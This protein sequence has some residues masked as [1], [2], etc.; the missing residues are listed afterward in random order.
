MLINISL[1]R[2]PF[3]GR[4]FLMIM[5]LLPLGLQQLDGQSI[6]NVVHHTPVDL[7]IAE[8]STDLTITFYRSGTFTESDSLN[9]MSVTFYR[10]GM[11]TGSPVE[12]DQ[13]FGEGNTVTVSVPADYIPSANYTF[14]ISTFNTNIASSAEGPITINGLRLVDVEDQM[15]ISLSATDTLCTGDALSVVFT[16]SGAP[17][18]DN[19]YVIEL[20]DSS[21]SFAEPTEIGRLSGQMTSGSVPAMI[22]ENIVPGRGYR[23]QLR[24]TNPDFVYCNTFDH[25]YTIIGLHLEEIVDQDGTALSRMQSFCPGDYLGVVFTN[26]GAPGEGNSYVVELSDSSGS[27]ATPTVIGSL[28]GQMTSGTVPAIIPK[29]LLS[30]SGYQVRIRSTNPDFVYCNTFDHDYTIEDSPEV[31]TQP[32]LF[33]D[34]CTDVT[35]ST[36]VEGATDFQWEKLCLDSFFITLL[37]TAALGANTVKA[38]AK[39]GDKLY[40]GTIAGLSYYD[41]SSWAVIN[42]G[43]SNNFINDIWV[44]P[45]YG[46]VY[47]STDGGFTI[48]NGSGV[49]QKVVKYPLI[50]SQIVNAIYSDSNHVFVATS[51]GLNYLNLANIL[52][53]LPT[54]S[55]STVL[56][57][58][59]V[60]SVAAYEV[61][62]TDRII[63][64]GTSSGLYIGAITGTSGSPTSFTGPVLIEATSYAPADYNFVNDV[65]VD[66]DNGTIY[67]ATRVG[68]AYST[69]GGNDWVRIVEG[70]E[71]TVVSSIFVENGLIFATT[72]QGL[73]VAAVGTEAFTLYTSQQ[74]IGYGELSSGNDVFVTS[75]TSDGTTTYSVNV[76]STGGLSQADLTLMDVSDAGSRI[77]GATTAELTINPIE[78]TD[79]LCRYRLRVS[80]GSSCDT[81]SRF[82]KIGDIPPTPIATQVFPSSNCLKGLG[83]VEISGLVPGVSYTLNYKGSDSGIPMNGED[84]MA[85]KLDNSG[86]IQLL[87]TG[88]VRISM[89]SMIA[90]GCTSDTLAVVIEGP[91]PPVF[92]DSIPGNPPA[93]PY[94]VNSCKGDQ[95]TIP[96]E[97]LPT[98]QKYRWFNHAAL[99]GSYT[100]TTGDYQPYPAPTVDTTYYAIVRDDNTSCI[101]EDTLQVDVDIQDRPALA[102]DS[103]ARPS[104]SDTN[105]GQILLGGLVDGEGYVITYT[106]P[107]GTVQTVTPNPVANA[108]GQILLTTLGGGAYTNIQATSLLTGCSSSLLTAV[109]L[110][111]GV[112]GPTD[113][114]RDGEAATVKE[115]SGGT[116][117]YFQTAN[118]DISCVTDVHVSAVAGQRGMVVGRVRNPRANIPADPTNPVEYPE[119]SEVSFNGYVIFDLYATLPAG[120]YIDKVEFAAKAGDTYS[121]S[122]CDEVPLESATGDIQFDITRMD[123]TL[124]YGPYLYGYNPIVNTDLENQKYA[125]FTVS[126]GKQGA[127]VDLGPQAVEDIQDRLARDGKFQVGL[128]LSG[129]DFDL[130]LHRFYGIVFEPGQSQQLRVTYHVRD[131]GDLS[132]LKYTVDLAGGVEGPWHRADSVDVDPDTAIV[133][134]QP[135]A[136]LGATPPDGE[137][138]AFKSDNATGDDVNRTSTNPAITDDEDLDA[139]IFVDENGNP[140]PLLAGEVVNVEIPARNNL[141]AN[142]YVYLFIDFNSDGD[143]ADEGEYH[144]VD[145]LSTTD[146]LLI[147]PA[148]GIDT[149]RYSFQAPDIASS[150]SIAV[151]VRI[152][153]STTLDAN[154]GAPNG[155]VED[156]LIGL[157]AKDFGDLQDKTAANGP[158]DFNTL[159]YGDGPRHGVPVI[160]MVYLGATVD[161]E[162]DGQP[163]DEADGD[164]APNDSL[165][166]D[167]DGVIFLTPFVPGKQATIRYFPNNSSDRPAMFYVFGDLNNDGILDSLAQAMIPANS[168]ALAQNLTFDVPEDATFDGGNA[169]FRFRITT[170]TSLINNPPTPYGPAD[171]GEV[172]DYSLPIFSIGNLV[173][174][175][176]NHNGFQDEEEISLG[177][178]SMRVVLRY[179][180]T[181]DDG[182]YDEVTQI[183]TRTNPTTLMNDGGADTV[184]DFVLDTL[185]A[186][187][188]TYRFIGLIE[189]NYQLIALD[190]FDLTPTRANWIDYVTEEDRDSDGIPLA[191][192]WA[193]DTNEVHQ[194]RT[195]VFLLHRDS[196]GTDEE[197]ILDQLNPAL[198]DPNQLT[199][200]PDNRFEQRIDFGYVAFDFGDLPTTYQTLEDSVGIGENVAG[201]FPNDSVKVGNP[202]E[203]PKHIVTPDIYLGECADAERLGQPDLDAGAEVWNGQGVVPAADGLG[204][205]PNDGGWNTADQN[206]TLA[207]VNDER[208]VTFLTPLVPGSE[209][210]ITVKFHASINLDGPDAYLQAYFDWNGD[211]DFY[212]NAADPAQ[213]LDPDEQ[214]LF[215]HLN[216]DT[217]LL[218]ANT[219]AVGLEMSDQ[220]ETGAIMLKF[221]VPEAALFQ[222]GN[223]LGRFRIGKVPGLGPTGILP[224]T[225]SFADGIVPLGE[226]EDYFL[227]LVRTSYGNIVWEDRDYDG[228][229]DWDEP[230]IPGVKVTIEYAGLDDV[231]GNDAF[232]QTYTTQTNADGAFLFAGLIGAETQTMTGAKYYR[233]IVEDPDNMTPTVNRD[234][235]DVFDV[236]NCVAYNS[237]GYDTNIDDRTTE[238]YFR[239]EGASAMCVGEANPVGGNDLGALSV[240]VG[241]TWPDNQIDETID[242]GFVAFDY[243]DLPDTS[244][245]GSQEYDYITSRDWLPGDPNYMGSRHAIQPRLY[246]G[247]GVDGELNGQPDLDAGSKAGGD[248]DFTGEDIAPFT[249]GSVTDGDDENGI[250][251]LTP[252]LPGEYAFIR[253]DYTSQDTVLGGGYADRQAFLNAFIDWNGDGDFYEGANF[254]AAEAITFEYESYTTLEDGEIAAIATP[255][256]NGALPGGENLY[257]IFG[258]RVPDTLTAQFYEGTAFM[259]FRLSWTGDLDPDNRRYHQA[260]GAQVVLDDEP[261]SGFLAMPPHTIADQVDALSWHWADT[262]QTYPQGEVED[263]AIPLAKVGNLSWYDHNV[264]GRQDG[265]L[266][267]LYNTYVD[268]YGVDTLHLV[269]IWGGVDH[270]TGDFDAVGYQDPDL[271]SA[272]DVFDLQY[273]LSIAPQALGMAPDGSYEPV[274][275]IKTNGQGLYSFRG[276]IPGNYYL[277]PLKYL[278]QDSAAFVNYWPKHRVLTVKQNVTVSDSLD[279]DAGPGLA[280]TIRD[281][282]PR[283]PEAGVDSLPL[284]EDGQLD[285]LDI[286]TMNTGWGITDYHPSFPDSLYDQTLDLG[287]VDEPNIETVLDLVGVDYPTTETGGN[288]N[289]IYHLYIKNPTE[290]P[291]DSIV[292]FLNIAGGYGDAF[293][294]GTAE[295]SIV[296]RAHLAKW[297][298]DRLGKNSNEEQ[299][300]ALEGSVADLTPYINPLYKGRDEGMA[301][302][303]MLLTGGDVSARFYLPGDSVICIRIEFEVNTDV[304]TREKANGV[305]CPWMLRSGSYARAVGFSYDATVTN[306]WLG[307]D[308]KVGLIDW[309]PRAGN[310]DANPRFGLPIEVSDISDEF[311]DLAFNDVDGK[312]PADSLQ[313]EGNVMDRGDVGEYTLFAT[314]SQTGRDKYEDEDD[315]LVQNDEGWDKAKRLSVQDNIIV[316]LDENC[317]A[318]LDARNFVNNYQKNL[319]FDVYPEGSYYR[320]IIKD[321]YTGEVL[322]AS[323]DRIPF[324]GSQYLDRKLIFEVRTVADLATVTWGRITI[325]DKLS[326]IVTCAENIDRDDTNNMLLN[327]MAPL[328]CTDIDSILNNPR[329]YLDSTYA[330]FTGI[331]T[332][333]DNCTEEVIF[334]GANDVLHVFADCDQSTA[335]G[336]AYAKITRTFL[337][338]DIFGNTASC[339]QEIYFYRPQIIL[340]DC[341]VTL[342]YYDVA[343]DRDLTPEDLVNTY[344]AYEAV[345][346]IINAAGDVVYLTDETICSFGISWENVSTFVSGE[347]TFKIEREWRV[348][349]WCY[350]DAANYPDY[351]DTLTNGSDCYTDASRE[352]NIYTFKQVLRVE[353]QIKPLVQIPDID[354]DGFEGSGYY[355]GPQA[356]PTVSTA[357]YDAEDVYVFSQ[358]TDCLA[359][360]RVT[361][362]MFRVQEDG[363]WC[364]D[365]EDIMVRQPVLDLDD[366][367]IPG[368]YEMVYD[369]QAQ[370]SGDCAGGYAVSAVRLRPDTSEHYLMRLRFFD[371]C[372]NDT[373]LYA[374]FEVLDAVKPV[375]LCKD[376]LRVTFDNVGTA[377]IHVED[378]DEG[379]YDNCGLLIWRKLRRPVLDCSTG[380]RSMPGYIDANNN[381]IIDE[382]DYIDENNNYRAEPLEYFQYN[383]EGVLMSPLLDQV[384][385]FCCD[386]DSVQV[387]LWASDQF[388]NRSNCWQNVYLE[389]KPLL[390]YALPGE[391]ELPANRVLHCEQEEDQL[392]WL[393]QSGVFAEGSLSYRAATALLGSDIVIDAPGGCLGF[394]KAIRLEPDFGACGFG[395]VAVSWIL[396]SGSEELTTPTRYIEVVAHHAY[397]IKFPQDAY[398]NCLSP[399]IDSVELGTAGCDLMAISQ[400]PDERFETPEDPTSCYKILRTWQVINWCEYDGISAPTIVSRDWDTQQ[401]TDC[402]TSAGAYNLNPIQPQ[403]DGTPGD[404]PIYVI[405]DI[406]NTATGT[407]T[408]YYDN[409]SYP[410]NTSTAGLSGDNANSTDEG[411]WWAV[412]RADSQQ[413]LEACSN[414]PDVWGAAGVEGAVNYGSRGFWQYTQHIIVQDEQDPDLTVLH[415]DTFYTDNAADCDAW[416]AISV[417]SLDGCDVLSRPVVPRVF[418]DGEEVSY[419]SST[420][421]YS[422]RYELGTHEL[423][424]TARD[425]CGNVAVH[426]GL[427]EVVDGQAPVPIIQE[428]VVVELSEKE[429]GGEAQLWVTDLIASDVYDCNGQQPEQTDEWGN[430]LV[431]QYSINRLGDTVDMEQSILLFDC[432]DAGQSVSIAVHAWDAVGNHAYAVTEVMVQD[433]Q[434]YCRPPAKDGRISGTIS[435]PTNG[436]LSAVE[437][438]LSGA[439]QRMEPTDIL[440]GYAMESLSE[441][442]DY[443]VTPVKDNFHGNGITTFDAILLQKHIQGSSSLERPYLPIAADVNRSGTITTLDLILLRKMI[444]GID[445]RFANN[446]SWRFV[447]AAYRFPAGSDPLTVPFPEARNVNNL[448]GDLEVNFVAIKTGDLN[449]SALVYTQPRSKDVLTIEA[450]GTGPW[451]L[452]DEEYRIDFK[453]E[454]LSKVQGYQFTLEL[455]T[456]LDLVDVIY[457]TQQAEHLGVF[458]DRG[459][460]TA[461]WNGLAASEALFSVV[462]RPREAVP[463]AEAIVLTS[464]YTTAEAYNE[465]DEIMELELSWRDVAGASARPVLYQ[466]EPNPYRAE[467]YISFHQVQRGSA[468]LQVRDVHGRLLLSRVGNYAAGLHTVRIKQEELPG[469][470]VY[471]YTL[472]TGNFVATRKMILL[473]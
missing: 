293:V 432:A 144:I 96:M 40:V 71:E 148:M 94:T 84:F 163:S 271:A 86:M 282:N 387:E 435:T 171:D 261:A 406:D 35:F 100:A 400:L 239:I 459:V 267:A 340:P 287:W 270:A 284:A 361:K 32:E 295:V 329:S 265:A 324:D 60:S 183:A 458:K 335:N 75:S 70:L 18:A 300:I 380:F 129:T 339:E 120:I 52:S 457:E 444:L 320:V 327:A 471:Y 420:G 194:A 131:Y 68:I 125:D 305:D 439:E 234:T 104:D 14:S 1:I 217:L 461:S 318:W 391:Y 180:G 390:E 28:P 450:S 403:G 8:G 288:F 348:L 466:N 248:D 296:E 302:D 24:S 441:G 78:Y 182:A 292:P 206:D 162:L 258:F 415:Q 250:R 274:G 226:V 139:N 15:G 220:Q 433:N 385:F 67:V 41:G 285:A 29:G 224:G 198:Q 276:L 43:L 297:V 207:C 119:P 135:T 230:V 325:E 114:F 353:D 301:T 247:D 186:H 79:A 308:T 118:P 50:S 95:I 152:S 275:I 438:H 470:G 56:V 23:I 430:A 322:W 216:G 252:L 236:S 109:L 111:Y 45:I 169:F 255:G 59:V 2:N 16:N 317:E 225:A 178:D 85:T 447:D 39:N 219:H 238:H 223:F 455:A 46:L 377:N 27:F 241:N 80:N 185:T 254:D 64:A 473:E 414:L 159:Q 465:E 38:V 424:V 423:L 21:G 350:S 122:L 366:R 345:P 440:G 192:P 240:A 436:R 417:S 63:Y 370:I 175:D 405:V 10:D 121:N 397:W 242:F 73:A 306:Q 214:I 249:Q 30:G 137:F 351:L 82:S 273:N 51:G 218:E 349:D 398:A 74:G 449:G 341:E 386:A 426:S 257:K 367:P 69:N 445:D 190:S 49:V 298:A 454:D 167:E 204:D 83:A 179:G 26:S 222:N 330:Y 53:P 13:T 333:V 62:A 17:S 203:G 158:N 262:L 172:E 142:V 373:L 294:P 117:G 468:S 211:G 243:G 113:N 448:E 5:L 165:S 55:F 3:E 147:V 337:F 164:D 212:L 268:E 359:S 362:D 145:T 177:I 89:T 123:D 4:S 7:C 443:T 191:A 464:S 260:T 210:I 146:S 401:G 20:S 244:S 437:V 402:G 101:S 136:F 232:E 138:V 97:D 44:D 156:F 399:M 376:A 369:D 37:D 469:A 154:G 58:N 195:E 237:D 315:Y 259:R 77:M 124:N 115:I 134:L 290:T 381:S 425:A 235:F 460:I 157:S 229:Q 354:E 251:L 316:G 197:G 352:G 103:T 200:F 110:P 132:E 378:V 408:V 90:P 279:S 231:F 189:G 407:A 106:D 396:S 65:F 326:P 176:R 463:R 161:T 140:T 368:A 334:D 451:L 338:R 388:G 81:Y 462:V 205:N 151:R 304:Y 34:T 413:D 93:D 9:K 22:P 126:S 421:Q 331:A 342:Y 133:N 416:V 472:E 389:N 283:N 76:A 215:T 92:G 127:W 419:S 309:M 33:Y 57:P 99:T 314:F 392:V 128:T 66:P 467:T 36:T 429:S 412:R 246:L 87:D 174:E 310:G 277:V 346:Y 364:F 434:G 344:G 281:E 328:V 456:A 336:Y 221:Q 166:D 312:M 360:F 266:E 253:V 141:I 256:V 393:Q 431:T 91:P 149:A 395:R 427:F 188:G 410:F 184:V 307:G 155:E 98:G 88:L 289:V 263:Y 375:L 196:L 303:T 202:L 209:A 379:S 227:N 153:S 193:Y 54:P 11:A 357:T 42:T 382:G 422:G 208:G 332:A 319:G 383:E 321:E 108:G 245:A 299:Q 25:D 187:N 418:I 47:L 12:T 453:C 168:G 291:L 31:T 264:N 150:D 286:A 61:N 311:D 374:P 442:S 384:P 446:T 112:D 116:S 102:I 323:V 355:N 201:I 160:P 173:W 404:E 452:A 280:F 347:C 181:R 394:E 143:F 107:M 105:D 358:G 428:G 170:D 228:I 199:A 72:T 233:I 371:E 356:S 363:D 272:G 213:G 6:I 269:L 343:T 409:D 48:L 130:P 372:G 313:F 365:L 278:Q 19:S 411:Y